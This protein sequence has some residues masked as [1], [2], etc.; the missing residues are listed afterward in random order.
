M[1]DMSPYTYPGRYTVGCAVCHR[2]LTSGFG[3]PRWESACLCG[4]SHVIV[5]ADLHDLMP[6]YDARKSIETLSVLT[7]SHRKNP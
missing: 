6:D 1:K 4:S 5:K 2:W 3:D 7:S